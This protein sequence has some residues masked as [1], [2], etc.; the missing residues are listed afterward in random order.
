MISLAHWVRGSW[1]LITVVSSQ[2]VCLGFLT[3]EHN[4]GKAIHLGS[5]FDFAAQSH[6]WIT[7]F[8]NVPHLS[9]YI[10]RL[11][12]RLFNLESMCVLLK[13]TATAASSNKQREQAFQSFTLKS[14]RIYGC[15]IL[16]VLAGF[17]ALFLSRGLVHT[18]VLFQDGCRP[19]FQTMDVAGSFFQSISW[20]TSAPQRESLKDPS[21]Q[22]S[23][24]SRWSSSTCELC[25]VTMHIATHPLLHHH[26]FNVL[27]S[28]GPQETNSNH[29]TPIFYQ[30]FS[31]WMSL[32]STASGSPK[33]SKLEMLKS[34]VLLKLRPN[35]LIQVDGV[36]KDVKNHPHHII[37]FCSFGIELACIFI[38][39]VYIYICMYIMYIKISHPECVGL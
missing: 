31:Y 35:N 19:H 12:L 17:Y 8:L 28:L 2:H 37:Q 32:E 3:R 25:I 39:Y 38:L 22:V 27:V 7:R 1:I 26:I 29:Q 14:F 34:G 11:I 4:C 20:S 6:D 10:R 21:I 15:L 24:V 5:D 16:W 9:F 13:T 30:A 23:L 33:K 18:W 36:V